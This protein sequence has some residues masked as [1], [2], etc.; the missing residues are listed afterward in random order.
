M[1]RSSHPDVFLSKDRLQASVGVYINNKCTNS[2]S[3]D[4]RLKILDEWPV[5]QIKVEHSEIDSVVLYRI[6]W[7]D[8]RYST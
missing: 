4:F 8:R 1:K 7:K 3:N 5:S 6:R 2:L